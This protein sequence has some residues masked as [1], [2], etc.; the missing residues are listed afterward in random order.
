MPFKGRVIT[1]EG[2]PQI[3]WVRP[4]D[5]RRLQLEHPIV[6]VNGA[7]DLL[8]FGHMRLI[9]QA[10]LRSRTLVVALDAD[11]KVHEAKGAGRPIMTYVERA[12]TLAY[13]DP[14]Y[15]VEIATEDDMDELVRMLKPDFRVQGEDYRDRESRYPDVKKLFVRRAEKG[16]STSQ[17]V[18][19]CHEVPRG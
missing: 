15:I 10:K 19:R 8:H 14:D 13:M 1:V 6:L 5:F 2:S 18:A 17:L 12:T 7:F 3:E 11:I 16:M 9:R 4:K